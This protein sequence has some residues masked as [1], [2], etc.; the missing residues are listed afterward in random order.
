MPSLAPSGAMIREAMDNRYYTGDIMPLLSY[1]AP[2]QRGVHG[3]RG[4]CDDTGAAIAMSIIGSASAAIGGA[5]SAAGSAGKDAG[6]TAAGGAISS[7]G[8]S[9]GDAWARTCLATARGEATGTTPSESVDDAY[10][11]AR[12]DMMADVEA[13]RAEEEI[14][15]S[16]Q[17]TQN[18]NMMI[19]LG[20][21]GLVAIVGVGVAVTRR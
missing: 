16:E 20:V 13:N 11:R 10:A 19:G 5:I 6:A 18:R 8:G 21:V 7:V 4:I 1:R 3:L 2:R 9:I 12:A 15:L 17:R 14:R